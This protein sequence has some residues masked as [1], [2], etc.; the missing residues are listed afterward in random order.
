MN[1]IDT[2]KRNFV[3]SG[4]QDQTYLKDLKKVEDLYKSLV[5]KTSPLK[6]YGSNGGVDE[7]QAY[8][9]LN[10]TGSPPRL[11][12]TA[13]V[14]FNG[15]AYSTRISAY[16]P[17]RQS[18]NGSMMPPITPQT[19]LGNR[20][21]RDPLKEFRDG[22]DKISKLLDDGNT[23]LNDM[24]SRFANGQ[25]VSYPYGNNPAFD[26]GISDEE[27]QL[28]EYARQEKELLNTLHSLPVGTKLYQ[29][30]L[31]KV[32][33]LS[34]LKTELE[35]IIREQKLSRNWQNQTSQL[36]PQNVRFSFIIYF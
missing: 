16:D 3:E 25:S 30:A 4:N 31:K 10:T 8:A 9:N 17:L 15:D 20:T 1:D 14:V 22:T 11:N 19:T 26:R 33:E 34:Q 23:T 29:E 6:T 27:N 36:Q 2:L 18:H 5:Q 28:Q 13:G 24:R 12:E 32:Q 7:Q 21:N 35:K